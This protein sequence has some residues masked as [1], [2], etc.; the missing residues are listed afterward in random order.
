MSLYKSI[1]IGLPVADLERAITWY[2]Q[3]LGDL[4]EVA[5]A[6]EVRELLLMT[7]LW[8]QLFEHSETISNPSV[9]RFETPDI[10]SSHQLAMRLGR[11]V[12]VIELVPEAVRYF[13]FADPFGNQLSFYQLVE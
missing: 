1:T 9:L 6:P 13:E 3:L 10:E 7:G 11:N 8:L 5:P 2:R 12:G 4:E